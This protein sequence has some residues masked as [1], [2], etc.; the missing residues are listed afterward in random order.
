MI[1]KNFLNTWNIHYRSTG[2]TL[3]YKAVIKN[4][5]GTIDNVDKSAYSDNYNPSGA[6]NYNIS[7]TKIGDGTNLESNTSYIFLGSGKT[8]PTVEDY[9]LESLIEYS[10]TGLNPLNLTILNKTEYDTLRTL[11]LTVRNDSEENIEISEIGNY[12]KLE[13]EAGYSG[14][15][16]IARETF[17]AITLTPGEVRSFTMTI[18]L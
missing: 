2:T 10:E 13:I 8:A 14:T 9:K 7:S 12:V 5:N 11:I 6:F 4:I 15:F 18:T 17:D 16:M 3:Y 1:N